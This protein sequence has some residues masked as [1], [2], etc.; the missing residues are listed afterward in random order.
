MNILAF[1]IIFLFGTII[2]SFLNVVIFRLNTGKSIA[3]GRSICMTCNRDLRWYELVPI[4]SF[5][6]QRGKCRRCGESISCQYPLVEFLTGITFVLIAHHFLP[7][8][9]FSSSTYLF[10][11]VLYAFIF[12]LLIIIGVYD[13]RHKVIPDKLVYLYIFISF[14]S[15]FLSPSLSHLIAGPIIALP[16]ALIWYL[17][18]GKWMGLGDAKLML[19]LGFML[20]LPLGVSSLILAFWIGA[21]VGLLIMSFSR[22]L[23]DDKVGKI[24][25][26]TEIPF[27]P[28]LIISAFIV[29]LFNLDIYTLSSLFL[30]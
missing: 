22:H 6:I 26:K 14:L 11:V 3:K 24:S 5:L 29:F 4:F 30:F 16:F 9:L 28:F 15:I 2:G 12:S 25:M 27:A 10:L 17:S 23:P 20:G 21:V 13:I 7:T 1:I 8:L 19:G 18:G